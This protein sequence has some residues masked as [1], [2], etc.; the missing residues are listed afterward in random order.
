MLRVIFNIDRYTYT[1]Q[2]TQG[3]MTPKNASKTDTDTNMRKERNSGGS[4]HCQNNQKS[5]AAAKA[6]AAGSPVVKAKIEKHR[7]K[8]SRPAR[9]TK[10]A[11]LKEE[12]RERKH[13]KEEKRLI[14]K[15]HSVK[16]PPVVPRAA[17]RREIDWILG[18]L[19]RVGFAPPDIRMSN[20]AISAVVAGAEDYL[21]TAFHRAQLVATMANRR[22]LEAS[23]MRLGEKLRTDA[24][25]R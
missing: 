16:G 4:K 13:L 9:G 20:A 25:L 18:D 14:E 1:H 15:S 10:Q 5:E 3:L 7:R 21:H 12:R 17:Y 19:C 2:Q 22:T 6:E 11:K 24:T 23:D 8:T